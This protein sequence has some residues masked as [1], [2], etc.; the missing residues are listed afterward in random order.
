VLLEDLEKNTVMGGM[1]NHNFSVEYRLQET[2]LF[3]EMQWNFD[4]RSSV[5]DTWMQ[6]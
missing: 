6:E 1:T 2:G 4:C 3:H 5:C